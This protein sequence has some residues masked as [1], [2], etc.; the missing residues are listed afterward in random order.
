MWEVMSQTTTMSCTIDWTLIACCVVENVIKDSYTRVLYN[1]FLVELG[2]LQC[3][4]YAMP[5][6]IISSDVNVF[7]LVENFFSCSCGQVMVKDK[8]LME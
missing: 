8:F 2:R 5:I 4:G 6:E 3:Y 7:C 1:M